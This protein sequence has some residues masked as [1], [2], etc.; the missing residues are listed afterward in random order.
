M[1]P[2][3]DLVTI[4]EADLLKLAPKAKREYVTAIL[5]SL[6]QM[7]AAGILENEYRWC[8][9]IA[10]CAHETGGFTIIRESLTYTSAKRLRTVWPARFRDKS[11]VELAPLLNNPVALG[12]AVYMGRMGNVAPGDG[13]KYRGAGALQTTGRSAVEKYARACGLDPNPELL[14]DCSVTM[15]FA[16][17]EWGQAGCNEHADANDILA[18][19]RAINVGSASSGVTPVG[20]DGRKECFAKAW[21]IWGIK[22]KPDT[23]AQKKMTGW[24]LTKLG[25]KIAVGVEVVKQGASATVENGIPEVPTVASKSLENVGAWKRV[26]QGFWSVGSEVVSLFGMTGR[27]WP[28]VLAAGGGAAGLAFLWWKKRG[29]DET[30]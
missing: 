28:Y 8:H 29:Q 19:S 22:G 21:G 3:S 14:D 24:D 30:S 12:D 10:Q 2:A 25:T 13:Y 17:V 5:G 16:I 11:D 27:L 7:R 26:G 4:T 18:V 20:L 6:S 1:I 15:Q 9:F 23:P